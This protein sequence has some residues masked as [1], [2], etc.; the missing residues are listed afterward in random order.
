MTND[1]LFVIGNH[2]LLCKYARKRGKMKNLLVAVLALYFLTVKVFF[3]TF[4]SVFNSQS[5]TDDDELTAYDGCYYLCTL[6]L[7]VQPRSEEDMAEIT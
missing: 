4:K 7:D 2:L 6:Y 3:N 5:K 1:C